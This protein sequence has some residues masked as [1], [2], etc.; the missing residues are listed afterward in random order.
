MPLGTWSEQ[1][2]LKFLAQTEQKH[3]DPEL[4]LDLLPL[5]SEG[6]RVEAFSILE[7]E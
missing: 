3:K 4:L 7:F 1:L 5:F 6:K 2:G